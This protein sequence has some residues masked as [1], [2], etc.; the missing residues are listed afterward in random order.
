MLT[1]ALMGGN[2]LS[3]LLDKLSE[4][5]WDIKDVMKGSETSRAIV[6]FNYKDKMVGTM[7]FA[8]IKEDKIWKIDNLST[9]KFDKF[10]LPQE[11]ED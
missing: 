5:E 8:M 4:C 3:V 7:E 9:P 11:K 10:T 2:A 1:G 6:G